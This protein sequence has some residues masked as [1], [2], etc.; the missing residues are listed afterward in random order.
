MISFKKPKPGRLYC[1]VFSGISVLMVLGMLLF[2]NSLR[3]LFIA[4]LIC[5]PFEETLTAMQTAIKAIAEVADATH[6]IALLQQQGTE[7]MNIVTNNVLKRAE[8]LVD[9]LQV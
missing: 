4:I 9:S 8:D 1:I 6:N 5:L 2:P 7:Q 3:I